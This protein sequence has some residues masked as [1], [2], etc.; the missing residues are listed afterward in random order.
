[1]TLTNIDDA[2]VEA[3]KQEF[4]VFRDKLERVAE[5]VTRNGTVAGHIMV[6]ND[7]PVKRDR[8]LVF[9]NGLRRQLETT[10]AFTS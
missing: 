8:N 9:V 3:A 7:R 2:T 4:L 10:G 5:C 6:P 1:M